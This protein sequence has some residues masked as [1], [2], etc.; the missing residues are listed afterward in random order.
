MKWLV[1]KPEPKPSP[2]EVA[3]SETIRKRAEEQNA[4]IERKKDEI[5]DANVTPAKIAEKDFFE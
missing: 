4:I 5:A 2:L 1:K 3:L